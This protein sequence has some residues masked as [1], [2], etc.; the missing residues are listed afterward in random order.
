M[1]AKKR[2]GK[3]LLYI[4][5]LAPVAIMLGYYWLEYIPSQREYFMNLRF[6]S[7]A[8][9]G[10]HLRVKVE[11][12]STAFNY[13]AYPTKFDAQA[14]QSEDFFAYISAIVPDLKYRA[15]CAPSDHRPSEPAPVRIEL[16]KI[17]FGAPGQGCQAE[18]LLS[19]IFTGF[20]R[21]DMFEDVLIAEGTGRVVYQRSVSSPRI[22]SLADLLKTVAGQKAPPGEG[23]GGDADA[24]R[25][26]RLDD[27]QFALLIQPLR[28]AALGPNQTLQ[29]CGLVRSSRLAQE[30]R[31]VPPQ[32]LL[33][34]MAPL[35]IALLS[36]PFLKILLLTRT[37]RLAF[38]DMALLAV[39]TLIS[40]SLITLAL[41]SG[42]QYRLSQ[43]TSEHD[44]AGFAGAL[45]E[46][47][48]A[49]VGRMR[50]V[51]DRFAGA[52]PSDAAEI[53]DRMNL[54]VSDISG[55]LTEGL[56]P[57]DFVF[58]TN[59]DGCQVAKWTTTRFNTRRVDQTSEE[60]FQKVVAGDLWSVEPDKPF[61]LHTIVSQTTSRLIVIMAIPSHSNLMMAGCG[62]ATPSN[63]VS[64]SLVAQL[65]ALSLPLV[66]PGAGFAIFQPDGLVL[67]HSQPER[68]LH[69]N[70]FE[71]IH[72]PA[73]WSQA[74]AM[75]AELS[76]SAYYRGRKYQFHV[77]PVK[78]IAGIPWNI[79]VFQEAEPRQAMIGVVWGETLGLFAT[80][81]G[82]LVLVS[83]VVVATLRVRGLSW[84]QQIDFFLDCLW[85]GQARQP[86]FQRLAWE[87]AALTLLSM[88]LVIWGAA[89]AYRS[90]GWMVPSSI[91]F[92]GLSDAH[93]SVGWLLPF[94]L[95]VPLAAIALTARRLWK[96]A[97][98]SGNSPFGREGRTAYFVCLSLCCVLMAVVPTLGLWSVCEAYETRASL[99]RWQQNL[100]RSVEA[101]RAQV[102]GYIE[103]SRALSDPVKTYFLSRAEVN[104]A[105][106][107]GKYVAQ[108]WQTT[109]SGP[110]T[111][112]NAAH[113][114]AAAAAPCR[115]L[116]AREYA[117]GQNRL[118]PADL[119][120]VS[121]V[122]NSD[123]PVEVESALPAVGVP[124]Q[125]LW[126]AVALLL[127]GV[128]YTWNR[129]ALGRLFLLD[130]CYCPL[131][132]MTSLGDPAKLQSHL[133]VLGLPLAKKDGAVR[134][135]LG[136]APPRV[137][138]YTARFSRFWVKDTVALLQ[139][140]L[141]AEAPRALAAAA[142]E[143]FQTA[144]ATPARNWVH[145][146]NLETKL[147][148]AADRQVTAD[149]IEKLVTMDVGGSRLRLVV[150]SVVDPMAHFDSVLND[151]R[152]KIYEHP[153]PEPELQ[154][155]A[156]L[157]HN[158][159]KVQAPGP[160]LR[161]PD[162]AVGH[163]GTIVYEE[164]RHQQA[165]LEV[166]REVADAALPEAPRERLLR[167]IAERA[168]ALYKL[169]WSSCTRSEK[170]ILIQLAQTGFVNPL[171][172]DTLEEL[173]RKGLIR[174]GSRP[175][176]MN[177]TFRRFLETV[178]GP[179][180]VRQW[181][182]EA[183]ESTWLI[184]R[185]VVL[186]LIV[187]ALAV[188]G[189]TQY[190]VMQTVTAALTGVVTLTAVLSRLLGY[191]TGRRVISPG[192]P[193]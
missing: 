157:L 155:L 92:A 32:Y 10:D 73:E 164:C 86:V 34:L 16:G 47:I 66:P 60:N 51:L 117:P 17:E 156:R 40:G 44:L 136:Y 116:A 52:L 182:S 53:H 38:H 177:E 95:L 1:N 69:E 131:P 31:H 110:F 167:M 25:T 107:E 163:A 176:V 151:E 133:L 173:I 172:R 150:T 79:A 103:S 140:Q 168:L 91:I 9:M 148:E 149:L 185:N 99:Q 89:D 101:R 143:S 180:T 33:V 80:L 153:L 100:V 121:C 94:C 122:T 104:S 71:E 98:S 145:V 30:A 37:G 8:M 97:P 90:A 166:G 144:P 118:A 105:R 4:L 112:Q 137:N 102:P 119:L 146:S 28:I 81:L 70:L 22:A 142:G 125:A 27:S 159:R 43:Q 21:D 48:L 55:K 56:D 162:W 138:L 76:D 183:G 54:P 181:E 161:P 179:D 63:I 141:A 135:W 46:Q 192:E 62:R 14:A 134:D 190:Q 158:F 126:W 78:G 24:E 2:L 160:E 165:L 20:T 7:L 123:S 5:C 57:F 50:A 68:N 6:R 67:F 82:L 96:P 88:A 93:R 87:L 84:R 191:F 58:W 72:S 11:R 19:Q 147:S 39:F 115:W 154:R 132:V 186:V 35:L 12:L 108:F 139:R 127:L 171:C 65:R 124:T 15:G 74:V 49:D 188:V 113:A 42:R 45:N 36:S 169:Y 175:R 75:R 23:N 184:I 61:T 109:I 41:V 59:A 128:A 120:K 187:V 64:V 111:G 129:N 85:P 13:A 170:L 29:I 189:L 77:Q 26:V 174:Q 178:E 83:V 130:F 152:K 18:A 3:W 114:P 106:A 193:A